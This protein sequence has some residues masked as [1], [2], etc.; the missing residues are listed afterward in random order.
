MK[1]VTC[2]VV[3]LVVLVVII[4]SGISAGDQLVAKREV[5]LIDSW[6]EVSMSKSSSC[7]L[8]RGEKVEVVSVSTLNY[9]SS[10]K[11]TIYYVKSTERNCQGWGFPNQFKR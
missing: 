6:D 4:F 2:V 7:E 10:D 11:E 5:D 8:V 1:T 9:G 3:F